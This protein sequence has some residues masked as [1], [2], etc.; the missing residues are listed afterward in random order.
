M[1]LHSR[2]RTVLPADGLTRSAVLVPLFLKEGRLHLLMFK[3]TEGVE[4]HK[5]QISF[6]GGVCDPG[7]GGLEGTALREADE[8]VG[9]RACD[10]ELLGMADDT[11]TMTGF[12]ITP[13]VGAIPHPYAFRTSPA[14][15][16]RLLMVPWALFFDPARHR[17]ETVEE[18]GRDIEV[19]F[20]D[21]EG[22]VIWGATARI[23]RGLTELLGPEDAWSTR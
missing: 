9:L 17:R 20:W 23:T 12:H 1:A 3:R 19:D 7:D 4:K 2:P 18:Q 5:G 6:P 10:V 13:V 11:R 15:V 22:V 14:E 16:E 8:E 21:F